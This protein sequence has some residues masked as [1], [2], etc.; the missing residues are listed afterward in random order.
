MF[1]GLG[2][3]YIAS[4]WIL[5][6][7]GGYIASASYDD[8]GRLTGTSLYKTYNPREYVE[9]TIVPGSGDARETF[10]FFNRDMRPLGEKSE[11]YFDAES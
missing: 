6:E 8:A 5:N 10:F 9:F 11:F 7:N 2:G 1:Y 3:V 4:A